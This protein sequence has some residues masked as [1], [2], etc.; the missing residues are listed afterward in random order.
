MLA[1]LRSPTAAAVLQRLA[2]G[3]AAGLIASL[4]RRGL[5]S[6]PA[7]EGGTL[8]VEAGRQCSGVER[9]AE[10]S[11]T[12]LAHRHSICEQAPSVTTRAACLPALIAS[13]SCLQVNP[14]KAHRIEPPSIT[15]SAT[16]DELLAYFHGGVGLGGGCLISS[17]LAEAP[18]LC[19]WPPSSAS[20]APPAAGP[21]PGCPRTASPRF[22]HP[23]CLLPPALPG[24]CTA[25]MYR[26]RRMEI[27]ADMLYKA[28]QIRGFCHLWVAAADS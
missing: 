6:A 17:A 20:Q 5:A 2:P 24:A 23:R 28:K 14:Y 13:A 27:T 26:L 19:K 18:E 16:K 10:L 1:V 7:V 8:T 3:A 11:C 4:Q 21:P 9:P 22:G 15:V 25:D 12:G